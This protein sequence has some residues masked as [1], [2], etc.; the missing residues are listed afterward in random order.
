MLAQDRVNDLE[1]RAKAGEKLIL[2]LLGV[3]RVGKNHATAQFQHRHKAHEDDGVKI[4]PVLFVKA[5][6]NPTYASLPQSILIALGLN[7]WANPGK[8]ELMTVQAQSILARSRT[9][10][11][12]WDEFQH[13]AKLRKGDSKENVADWLKNFSE[14][15]GISIILLGTPLVEQ[16]L[17]HDGQIRDRALAPH[18]LLPYNWGITRERDEF[19]DALDQMLQVVVES[20]YVVNFAEDLNLPIYTSAG[21][22]IGMVVKLLNEACDMARNSKVIDRRVLLEAHSKSVNLKTINYNPFASSIDLSEGDAVDAYFSILRQSGYDEGQIQD[23][24]NT[25]A[26]SEEASRLRDQRRKKLVEGARKGLGC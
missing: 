13:F 8:P 3:T 26:T 15:T 7:A 21:G 5:P 14:V 19:N 17:D 6:S 2:P 23:I 25:R 11:I 16:L 10:Y 22:R 1:R 4:R 24:T 9:L 18:H 12:I 20:G